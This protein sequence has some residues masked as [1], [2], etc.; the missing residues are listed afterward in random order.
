MAMARIISIDIIALALPLKQAFTIAYQ[1]WE[2]MPVILLQVRTDK[3]IWGWGEA[4]PDPAVSGETPA[5]CLAMLEKDLA[6]AVL[7]LEATDLKAIHRALDFVRGA[8]AAKAAIDIACYDIL[9][10]T[11]QLPLWQLLGGKSA[12]LELPAVIPL[13]SPEAQAEKA[14]YWQSQGYRQIKVK[15]GGGH[16]EDIDRLKAVGRALAPETELRVDVNQGWTPKQALA[17]VPLLQEANVAVLEQPVPWWELEAMQKI[18]RLIPVMADEAVLNLSDLEQVIACKA[19]SWLNIKL[20]KC[21]GIHPGLA[22]VARARQAG[23]KVLLGSMLESAL[24]SLA[25]VHM[26]AAVEGIVA[27]EMVG[28]LLFACDTGR[29]PCRGNCIRLTATP[30][31]GFAPDL[32]AIDRMATFRVTVN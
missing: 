4:V 3:G 2:S 32:E 27:N 28:P 29:F 20:M 13:A 31:L 24:G 12:Q 15:L 5:S 21:G 16:R 7:G 23:I 25:G 18:N 6:P 19:A 9:G 11:R 14:A 22:L 26:A 10:K 8:P 17:T 1:A 30:G